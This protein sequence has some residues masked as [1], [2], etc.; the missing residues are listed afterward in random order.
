MTETECLERMV[1]PGAF[2][3]GKYGNGVIQ[4]HLT[5]TCNLSCYHCT[6]GSQLRG[7][8]KFISLDNFE[9]TV[10]D[11]VDY[12]GVVGIFGGNPAIHPEFHQICDILKRHIPFHRRGIWCNHPLGK[13]A[14]MRAT[15]N[16]AVS[17]LNV[18][19]DEAA[20]REFRVDWPE[21]PVFG[22]RQDS[23]HSPIFVAMKD[24]I[25]DEGERWRLI[26]G[27]DINH[28]WSA[29]VGEFRGQLRAWFCEIAGAQSILHQDE[30]EYPD[31]GLPIPSPTGTPWWRQPM[32][33]FTSQ[34]RK[35]CHECSVPL[36][37]FGELSQ[38]KDPRAREQVSA[39]HLAVSKPKSKERRT[40]VVERLEQL[41]LGRL[42][43]MTTYLQN[44]TL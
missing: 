41:N 3:A 25:A 36:Q 38:S 1:P 20:F 4:I 8:P 10:R 17:N 11:L 12:H 31:T 6:Q 43:H 27:C 33:F 5:R 22:L 42:R 2:K 40:E 18:H 39:T 15:F 30:P 28:N 44:G 19:L 34:V 35:H 29:M 9:K 16:P 14:L 7:K 23:R 13:A 32:S 24:V 37:G 26:S 21:A